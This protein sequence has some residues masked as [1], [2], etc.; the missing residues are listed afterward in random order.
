MIIGDGHPMAN[1]TA[2]SRPL[3]LLVMHS[4][5][6]SPIVTFCC[7]HTPPIVAAGRAP[8]AYTP[9]DSVVRLK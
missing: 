1:T 4:K 2:I 9:S 3:P 7:N 5:L 8:P 6:L